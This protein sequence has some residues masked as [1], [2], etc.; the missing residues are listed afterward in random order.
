MPGPLLGRG[1]LWFDSCKPPPPVS[2]HSVFAFWVVAY[3]RFDCTSL[4]SDRTHPQRQETIV[5]SEAESTTIILPFDK[6]PFNPAYG[7]IY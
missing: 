7:V 5:R 2:D 4:I 3:G 1:A 6:R